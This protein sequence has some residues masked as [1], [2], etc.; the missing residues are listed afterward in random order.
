VYQEVMTSKRTI[1]HPN[2]VTSK[3]NHGARWQP[4]RKMFQRATSVGADIISTHVDDRVGDMEFFASLED[5]SKNANLAF[6]KRSEIEAGP[7]WGKG[8][9]SET[10]VVAMIALDP[11][12]TTTAAN[13]KKRQ[14]LAN[15]AWMTRSS[16]VNG[17]HKVFDSSEKKHKEPLYAIKQLTH[18]TLN[19]SD[20]MTLTRAARELVNDAKYLA[21]LSHHPNIVTLRGITLDAFGK[22][23]LSHQ[24]N[25]FFLVLD[26]A[27]DRTLADRIYR[28]WLTDPNR[29]SEPEEDLIPMK[30]NYAFQIAKALRF[31]HEN[32]VLYRDLKPTNVGFSILDPHCVQLLDFGIARDMD[33]TQEEMPYRMTLAGTR[34]YVAGEVLTTGA[35]T[36]KSDVYSWSMVYYEMCT[37]KKPYSR[38]SAT[39][40]QN[41]VC[42]RGERPSIDDYYFPEALDTILQMSWHVN[43]DKRWSMDQVCQHM[44]SFLMCLDGAYYE[45]NE[46]DFLFDIEL[47]PQEHVETLELE[48]GME[49]DVDEW[50][51]YEISSPSRSSDDP[52]IKSALSNENMERRQS[53]S[54]FT[55]IEPRKI[56]SEAA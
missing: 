20:P 1:I 23:Y 27:S 30:A 14:E 18:Q 24:F 28:E 17:V 34:R 9:F 29:G 45:H 2:T 38:I 26:R 39:D 33:C 54:S 10:R 31:C 8:T 48:E 13:K 25:D 43:L 40:H 52:A 36:W 35:Y 19:E 4:L 49:L 42:G 16:G 15:A 11:S 37:E 55:S 47:P 22:N 5:D 6:L 53:L 51:G 44:Q 3:N 50:M 46:G 32:K 56:I 41:Y 21:R 7:L 12:I